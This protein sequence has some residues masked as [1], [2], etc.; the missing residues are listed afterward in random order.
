MFVIV[1]HHLHPG[2]YL[3][4]ACLGT[5]KFLG[6]FGLEV[7]THTLTHIHISMKEEV[8]AALPK[9]VARLVPRKV[10]FISDI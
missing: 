10:S 1:R 3:F 5:F 7:A 6:L 4:S 9:L 2:D 8:P